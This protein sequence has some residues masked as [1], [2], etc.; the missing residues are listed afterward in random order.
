MISVNIGKVDKIIIIADADGRNAEKKKRDI[1]R[2]V[3]N[4][5]LVH[6]QVVLL[7]Y[8]IEEWICY[9]ESISF[10]N[11]KPSDVLK[12]R[13][14]YTKN[15]LPKYAERLDCKKLQSCNSFKRLA[16]SLKPDL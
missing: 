10:G 3:K 16:A 11:Q 15:Q 12:H 8:E 5:D 6:V 7:N 9:S 1:L 14:N 2:F 4:E 13:K